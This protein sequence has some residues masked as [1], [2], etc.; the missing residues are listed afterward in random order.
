MPPMPVEKKLRSDAKSATGKIGP[1]TREKKGAQVPKGGVKNQGLLARL[2]AQLPDFTVSERII[3]NYILSNRNSIAFETADAVAEKLNLGAITVGRFARKLGYRHFKA[4]KEDLRVDIASTPWLVGDQLTAFIQKN[5]DE[6]QTKKSLEADIAGV[7]EVYSMAQTPEWD[8][9]VSMIAEADAVHVA[10]FQTERGL[11]LYL[12]HILQYVRPDVYPVDSSSGN[13]AD[14][15]SAR[16]AKPCV[17]VIETRRYSRQAYLLAEQLHKQEIDL[18]IVS[19]RYCDWAR[20]FTSHYLLVPTDSELFWNSMV[21]MTC[22]LNL[23]ANGVVGKLGHKVEA[24]L[25]QIS[26]YYQH[27]TG[28]VSSGRS[29]RTT[30]SSA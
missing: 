2:E 16:A 24:R 6:D 7:I 22:A 9:M 4:L 26:D 20:K 25:A 17:I 13:Y 23:L 14:V 10:G 11:G 3:A 18:I 15:L 30:K 19:D 28:H 27:F 21:P 1:G 5:Q 8:A 29:K 12:A